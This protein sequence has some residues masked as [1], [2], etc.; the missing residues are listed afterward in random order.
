MLSLSFVHPFIKQ[1]KKEEEEEKGCNFKGFPKCYG[2]NVDVG[3]HQE[4][5]IFGSYLWFFEGLDKT[6]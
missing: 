4:F 6:F 2:D 3:I 5:D 1:E